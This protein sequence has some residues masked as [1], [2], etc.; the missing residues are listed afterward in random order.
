VIFIK[1]IF[2]LFFLVIFLTG[3]SVDYKVYIKSNLDVE[4]LVMVTDKKENI[5]KDGN[6]STVVNNY[7]NIYKSTNKYSVY[8]YTPFDKSDTA[9]AIASRTYINLNE[10]SKSDFIKQIYETLSVIYSGDTITIKSE[11]AFYGY[12]FFAKDDDDI[13]IFIEKVNV[14][15]NL[16]FEVISSNADKID[17][18]NYMWEI[19]RNT[20]NKSIEIKFNKTKKARFNNNS[21][22]KNNIND[23]SL[24][25]IGISVSL[26]LGGIFIIFISIIVRKR[27]KI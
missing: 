9:G 16:P 25:N 23:N 6:S 8:K 5:N 10:Y 18:D 12:S 1:R 13:P 20:T 27:N 26:I 22:E 2:C 19:D 7:I 21:N 24:K 14:I 4:E 3:C 15:I 17:K 11:G